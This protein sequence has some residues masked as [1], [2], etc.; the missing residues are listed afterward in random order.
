VVF[1]TPIRQRTG[2]IAWNLV[3]K[4]QRPTDWGVAKW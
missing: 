2:L 4:L 3:A 1:L